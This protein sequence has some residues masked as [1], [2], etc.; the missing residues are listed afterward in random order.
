MKLVRTDFMQILRIECANR[1]RMICAVFS[2]P[3]LDNLRS[4]FGPRCVF[5]VSKSTV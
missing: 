5:V 2:E 1:P 3:R 4:T